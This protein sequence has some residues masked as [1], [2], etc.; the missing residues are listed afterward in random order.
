[1]DYI[2][3]GRQNISDEDINEVVKVLRSDFITQG[4]MVPRFENAVSNYAGAEYAVAVNSAT[5]ALHV[6]C[7]SLGVSQDDVVWTSAITFVASANCARYCQADVDFVDI[8]PR[9]FN[10]CPV[11]LENKLNKAKLVNRLPKVVIVVHMCGQPCDMTKI[12]ILS[13]KFGFSVIEDASHAI[14]SSYRGKKLG[15]VFLAILPFLV[16]IL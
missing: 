7:L 12:S 9:T 16:F 5:S 8:D 13:K 15:V 4:P 10:I 6:A 3:Y 2:P 1:M 11:A 14:G